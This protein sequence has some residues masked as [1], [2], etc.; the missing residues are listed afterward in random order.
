MFDKE[1]VSI[2]CANHQYEYIVIDCD[3]RVMK[4]SSSI[5]KY[6][7]EKIEEGVYLVSL[8]SEFVGMEEILKEVIDR[9]RDTLDIP[10][11]YKASQGYVNIQIHA[12]K[13]KHSGIILFEDI[14]D[15]IRVQQTIKQTNNEN[16]L[17]LRELAEK[18]RQLEEFNK[19]MKNLVDKEVAKNLEKQHIIEIQSRH[20]QMGEM[21]AMITHQ[22]KQPLSA[23]QTTGMLL[24]IKY[25]MGTLNKD[26]FNDKMDALL[27]QAIHMNQTVKDFQKF[28][29]PSKEKA[30]FNVKETILS[31]LNLVNTEYSLNNIAI[32][33]NG[34][35]DIWAFGYA[36][37][38]NQ[39]I[40]SILGNAKDA[41]LAHPHENMK[42]T[43]EIYKEMQRSVVSIRDNAGGI[44]E[45]IIENIFIQYV[46]GKKEGSGLGLYIAKRMIEEHMHGEIIANNLQDGAHFIIRV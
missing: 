43:I 8:F 4:Y 1:I 42:I 38:Y 3:L 13:D 24:K 40:L 20:A 26:T 14:T 21:I 9:K 34:E 12:G 31:V 46:S 19:E 22:W 17:L 5:S 39:V 35:D 25:Q 29:T 18:N 23:I 11:V 30:L 28:F 44:D 2:I 6:C 16:A 32:S 7:E 10:S 37:E 33:V 36:N 41:F 45:E 15:K 27:Q